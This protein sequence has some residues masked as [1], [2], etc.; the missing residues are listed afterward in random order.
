MKKL[1]NVSIAL[2][3]VIVSFSSNIDAQ[4]T[5]Q[6]DKEL[7]H[8]LYYS[9][10]SD[11]EFDL[12]YDKYAEKYGHQNIL[13]EDRTGISLYAVDIPTNYSSYFEKSYFYSRSDGMT[14]GVWWKDFLFENDNNMNLVMAKAGKAWTALENKHKTNAFWRNGDSLEA[15]FHCHAATVGMLKKPWNIEPWRTETNVFLCMLAGCNPW[16]CLIID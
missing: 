6:D 15:Q 8:E 13:P 2:L 3:I 10:Y 12:L 7:I 11:E 4:G 14:L 16:C 1:I 9:D 5:Y